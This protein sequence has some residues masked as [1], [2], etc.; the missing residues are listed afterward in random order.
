[1]AVSPAILARSQ[2]VTAMFKL[3]NECT[4]VH[5]FVQEQKAKKQ[6]HYGNFNVVIRL[7]DFKESFKTLQFGGR[8]IDTQQMKL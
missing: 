2:G 7:Y 8:V 6:Q 5:R 1:M 3:I 4:V